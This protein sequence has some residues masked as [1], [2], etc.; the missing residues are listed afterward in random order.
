MLIYPATFT[1]DTDYIMVTFPDIPEAITQ[2]KNF[3]EAYEMAVEVLG[4]ALED[5]TD[6]PKSSS[7]SDLK[8]QYP[9]SDIALIGIDMIAYMK[10]YHSKKVR[11]NVT[12]P[13]WL[14]NAAEDKNLNF[15]QVLTEALELKLQ[16]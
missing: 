12:I 10:K 4:F 2:G 15:S 9:D 3:Q 13:E 8:E 14:N 7:V 1:Q 11:K 5:Y 6:Y 16:A